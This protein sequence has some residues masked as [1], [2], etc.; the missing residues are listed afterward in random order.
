M[1]ETNTYDLIVIGTGVAATTAAWKC[2]SAGWSVAIIDSR[3]FGG[4]CALRGC[5]PK[6]V[7]VGAAEVIDMNRRMKG[8]GIIDI[9]E[10]K[11]NWHDLMRFKRSFTEPVPK[12][13]EQQ[14]SKAGIVA[15]HG[16][17]RF[18]VEQSLKLD[19]N[20]TLNGGHILLATGAQPARLNIPGEENMIKSDR[21]L[22]LSE[23]P[24]KIVFVGGGYISFE[25]AHIAARAGA[26]VTILHRGSRPL[27]NF[28]P[29][30]V[31]MLL[32]RTHELG[33]AVHLETR[34]ESI[35][36]IKIDD[37]DKIGFVV[38]AINTAK[39]EKFTTDVVHGGSSWSWSSAR[40]R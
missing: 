3:P 1:S 30:L 37:S 13:R 8:K 12:E 34:V 35:D 38:H 23:L 28:D 11:I 20:H 27:N 19:D 6:K 33:I 9:D 7:L 22:E 39:N 36:S 26:N 14:F 29:Y 15:Y 31:D 32:Q 10:V 5:D 16:R 21:F 17:A 18:V 40:T 25:F 24:S 4:T 2:R